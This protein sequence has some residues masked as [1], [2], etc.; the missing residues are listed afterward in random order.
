V[1]FNKI[2]DLPPQKIMT[3]RIRIANGHKLGIM[4]QAVLSPGMRSE[5]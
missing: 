4:L 2:R 1:L 5:R 3:E